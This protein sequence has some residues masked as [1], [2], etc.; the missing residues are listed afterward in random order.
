MQS[1]LAVNQVTQAGVW[2]AKWWT[3]GDDPVNS[4]EWGVWKAKPAQQTVLTKI[5]FS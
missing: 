1:T 2:E 4:G 5:G 3:K